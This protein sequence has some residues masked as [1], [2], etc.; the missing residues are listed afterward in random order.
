MPRTKSATPANETKH[1]RWKRLAT[2]RTKKILGGMRTLA[3]LANRRN[4]EYDDDD[5]KKIFAA[6]DK[7]MASLKERFTTTEKKDDLDFR[8]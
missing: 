8:L 2:A 7:E 4:Y 5:V 3:K 1:D 6:I